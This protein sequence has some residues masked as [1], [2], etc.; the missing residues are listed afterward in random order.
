M[1]T[2]CGWLDLVSSSQLAGE[3]HFEGHWAVQANLPRLVNHSHA[4]ARN[5]GLQFIVS[6]VAK[7]TRGDLCG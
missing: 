1:G 5:L 7:H 3:D 4:A 2:M 6:K